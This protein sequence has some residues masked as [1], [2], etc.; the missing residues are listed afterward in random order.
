GRTLAAMDIQPDARL[1]P[2]LLAAA[3][4]RIMFFV[5]AANVLLA[6]AWWTAWL[7]ANRWPQLLSMPQP[8]PYA[9]RLHAVVMQYQMLPSFIFGFLLTTFPRWI[10][11]PDAARCRCLPVGAG[12]YG[13]QVALLLCALGAPA[14][15]L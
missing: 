4:H 10:G 11:L 13:G 7:V 3:P 1:S 5:G 12:M 8:E 15:S 9:G 2:R 14:G 6:M